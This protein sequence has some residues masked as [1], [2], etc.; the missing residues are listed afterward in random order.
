MEEKLSEISLTTPAIPLNKEDV[1][2]DYRLAYRSREVSLL[3][4]R[5]VL[6]GKAKFGIFGDGKEVAQ[7]A[8]SKV[9]RMGDIRSGYYR[10]QTFAFAK[11]MYSF[12]GFFSQLYSHIDV[13][14]DPH[15]GGRMMNNHIATRLLDDRGQWKNIREMYVSSAD[16]SCTAAQMPR[17]V[18]L[19]QAS[20]LY[21]HNPEL[22]DNTRFSENGNEIVFGTIGNGSCAEGHFWEAVNAIGVLGAPAIISIWDD[23]YGISVPNELQITKGDLSEVLNGFQ[24]EKGGKG[25]ELFCVKAWDYPALLEVYQKA[26]K[27]AREEHIPSIIHVIEVTQPQGHSTSGSHE[28]YKSK[29]RL[30]Q[31]AELDCL[32]RMRNWILENGWISE[33][34]LLIWEKED[35]KLIRKAKQ[36]A[37]KNYLEPIKEEVLELT[38]LYRGLIPLVQSKEEL[39]ETINTL[40]NNDEPFRGELLDSVHQVLLTMGEEVNA[41]DLIPLRRWR[42]QLKSHYQEEY[43]SYLTSDTVFS[44]MNV[45]PEAPEYGVNSP[46]LKGYEILNR[47]FDHL[48]SAHPEVVAFGE[49]VGQLGDVNQGFAGLQDKYGKHRIMDTGIREATIMGQAIG[50]ALRGLRPIA[51]IQ[52][53]DYFIYGMQTLSDDLASLSYRTHRG[54]KAPVIIRTRGHRLEGI[55]H[56]GSPM[57]MIIHALRGIHVCVPRNM[58]QAAGMYNTL[59]AGDEPAVVVE[60]LN[61]YRL[62]EKL[63]QNLAT[64]KVPLGV[65]ECI[66]EGSDITVVTYGACCRLALEAAKQLEEVGIS[67]EVIDIQT[68]LPFDTEHKI[69]DSIKKTNRVM[70]LDEDVPGGASAYMMQQVLEKQGAYRYLDS[71]PTTLTAQAHRCAYGTDGDYFS[72]PQ[73]VD[74]FHKVYDL[75]N[76]AEPSKFP[77]LY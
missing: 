56:A 34:E 35:K 4:R 51:E 55:W 40:E 42:D 46:V 54:Q 23:E 64:L 50:L 19:A 49:D 58:V 9:F 16:V 41:S 53:L 21:R 36:T 69:L 12:E 44:P 63:P 14:Y 60:V 25:Y 62:K 17:L 31:E 33:E 71:S 57:G 3:G 6:T 29:E 70:F 26:E 75:M 66:R 18:G 72:K 27:L 73:T 32:S 13:S 20:V 1:L 2:E 22:K 11:G 67:V 59:I 15:S 10:D 76:E 47:C 8:M 37:W 43:S 28:R 24:R 48:F 74:I 5:E 39:T 52:Y 7:L 45:H 65:P 38:Q 68:L 77:S 30:A 61:G